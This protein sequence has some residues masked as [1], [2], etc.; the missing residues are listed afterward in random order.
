[1]LNYLAYTSPFS[2][3][4]ASTHLATVPDEAKFDVIVQGDVELFTNDQ[5]IKET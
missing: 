5:W 1:M 3:Y 2:S 4:K